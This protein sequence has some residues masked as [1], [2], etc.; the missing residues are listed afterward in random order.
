M[1]FPSRCESHT[2]RL[3]C[4]QN[5]ISGRCHLSDQLTASVLVPRYLASPVASSWTNVLPT[6]KQQNSFTLAGRNGILD[7][8][9][10]SAKR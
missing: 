5:T 10:K 2:C 6:G 3:E 8:K 4:C 9:F 7:R 1:N